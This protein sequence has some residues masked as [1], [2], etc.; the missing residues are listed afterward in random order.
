MPKQRKRA[1]RPRLP[2][3]NAKEVMLRVRITPDERKAIESKAKTGR[4]SVSQWIRSI[5]SAA[6]EN[7]GL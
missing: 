4:V 2:E 5:L 7:G 1:G 6:L 3:G